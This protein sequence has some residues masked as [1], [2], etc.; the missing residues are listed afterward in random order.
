MGQVSTKHEAGVALWQG[1]I[2]QYADHVGTCQDAYCLDIEQH[3]LLL[4]RC[5]G[6]QGDIGQELSCTAVG[7]SAGH[8]M[9][10]RFE[11]DSQL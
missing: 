9:L 11:H 2:L 10:G 5:C 3:S 1:S 6:K 7:E 8:H 4:L